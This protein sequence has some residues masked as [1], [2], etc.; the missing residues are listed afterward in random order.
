M[1][2]GRRPDLVRP[3]TSSAQRDTPVHTRDLYDGKTAA[4]P[5]ERVLAFLNGIE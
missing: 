2:R 4:L 3:P 5:G 1:R